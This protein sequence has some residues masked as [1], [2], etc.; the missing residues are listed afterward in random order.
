VDYGLEQSEKPC[1]LEDSY[2]NGQELLDTDDDLCPRAKKTEIV[3]AESMML[4]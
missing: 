2:K 4:P 3:G 1:P